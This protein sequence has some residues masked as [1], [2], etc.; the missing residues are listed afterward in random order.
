[1]EFDGAERQPASEGSGLYDWSTPA[2]LGSFVAPVLETTEV[3]TRTLQAMRV[4]FASF[5]MLHVQPGDRTWK[6]TVK[7]EDG[8]AACKAFLQALARASDLLGIRPQSRAYRNQFTKNY[9]ALFP[10]HKRHYRVDVLEASQEGYSI[11][12]VNGERYDFHAT[13]IERGTC[14]REAWAKTLDVLNA[15]QHVNLSA[16][17]FWRSELVPVLVELD[18]K[19]AAFEE[20]Y[21][22]ELIQI[23]RK[24]RR[25]VMD[26]IFLE[27]QLL[28]L[29]GAVASLVSQGNAN[30]TAHLRVWQQ[31]QSCRRQYVKK[32]FRLNAV[33]NYRRKGH[34]N[35][36][37]GV[38]E[39]SENIIKT[40]ES[41]PGHIYSAVEHM[42]A[43]CVTS[44]N[45]FRG[46]INELG[47]SPER[48]DPHLGNNHVLVSHLCRVEETWQLAQKYLRDTQRLRDLLSLIEFISA[49]VATE[50]SMH[51]RAASHSDK[52][53]GGS[54][55]SGSPGSLRRRGTR[56]AS[57]GES[58]AEPTFAAHVQLPRSKR[59]QQETRGVS[60]SCSEGENAESLEHRVVNCDVG[61]FLAVS[62]LHGR[63]CLRASMINCGFAVCRCVLI[64]GSSILS[65][66]S[67]SPVST[68]CVGTA[69]AFPYSSRLCDGGKETLDVGCA[70]LSQIPRFVCL[71]YLLDPI[72]RLHLF[73]PF[74]P[75]LFGEGI[76]ESLNLNDLG[77]DDC[78]SGPS[79]PVAPPPSSAHEQADVWAGEE[80]SVLS[81]GA[82][83]AW[84]AQAGAAAVSPFADAC[85]RAS[86]CAADR[87]I[88]PEEAEA[89]AATEHLRKETFAQQAAAA[90]AVWASKR[91]QGRPRAQATHSPRSSTCTSSGDQQREFESLSST[92]ASSL[93]SLS[94]SA[95]LQDID[96]TSLVP[97]EGR[98]S[99][100]AADP[101][102][103]S[104]TSTH[105][106][107]AFNPR[108]SDYRL[109]GPRVFPCHS[110]SDWYSSVPT[111]FGE[112]GKVWG[113]RCCRLVLG[114]VPRT[115]RSMVRAWQKFQQWLQ[116][117]GLEGRPEPWLCVVARLSDTGAF[118]ALMQSLVLTKAVESV[119]MAIQRSCAAEWNEFLQVLITSVTRRLSSQSASHTRRSSGCSA[120]GRH[121]RGLAG[122]ASMPAAE[123]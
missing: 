51:L 67:I 3:T 63:L 89:T 78:S 60:S 122:D 41:E 55:D 24:A 69:V 77:E 29:D 100:S 95:S 123:W 9:K 98:R 116:K 108:E 90:E 54:A 17:P 5:N 64:I 109:G 13:V 40:S 74:L 86:T 118:E 87:K 53:M 102:C 88:L 62:L 38:L 42:A 33:A 113:P 1:M 37:L 31:W 79:T 14:F 94:L 85:A 16:S 10:D 68:S 8:F 19:W 82:R 25:Y 50:K 20:E 107:H 101:T 97:G 52:G 27:N 73:R 12:Y 92:Q 112:A 49:I 121:E 35:L 47:Q 103:P 30:Q 56:R 2:S 18:S 99:E 70:A 11:I 93:L 22:L 111:P 45:D 96:Q 23:E 115:L 66:A 81:R 57:C 59:Q 71:Y 36:D 6:P 44:F 65:P 7:T 32:V 15:M 104:P 91:Q 117:A 26:V 84:R 106:S 58:V 61:A 4:L 46:H 83:F 120:S 114:K 48:V 80:P 34:S 110:D 21:I 72:H 43:E 105:E 76:E 39:A 119:S 75:S 28:Y